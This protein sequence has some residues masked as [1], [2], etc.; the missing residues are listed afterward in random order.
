MENPLNVWLFSTGK[1]VTDSTKQTITHFMFN[2]GK[3]DI[4]SDHETFQE[5]Y[6]KYI[7]FKNCIVEKKTD[8]FKFFVDFDILSEEII[9]LD[10]YVCTIQTTLS[11]LY[12][13]DSLVCIVTGADKNKEVTKNGTM[14]LKQGF[15]LHWPDII[16][17]KETAKCIRKNLVIN[18]TNIFG[19]ND[20]HF[21]SWEK[22]IDK[23]VYENNGLR[24]VGSDKCTISDGIKHYE[25][26]IYILKE[27][28]IETKKDESLF[29]FYN[30][31]TFHLVKDTS[32]RSDAKKI[33]ETHGFLEY[34]E[35]E[36]TIETSSG[37]LVTLSRTS[38]EYK[39]IEKFFKL[40]ATGYRAEDIRA[41]SQ[42]K[43]KFMYLINSKSKYCQNKQD[44]HANNHIYFKLSPSGLCQKCM[45]ENE[46]IHGPCR[47]FQSTCVPITTSLESV[48][49][50]KKP[51]SKEVKKPQDFSLPGL[52]EK[53]ENNIT[54]K[55][56]FMGPGKKK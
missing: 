36:E 13:K 16:V 24:L 50:W 17:D 23:C 15:H 28:Y 30:T 43:D 54:S 52:L 56:N 51:K 11:N 6:S 31:D 40:H 55:D 19:K 34:V 45:S 7:K 22:I 48:L 8:F 27:V 47:E 32:I 39:A 38:V 10:E 4:S 46:G 9:N 20:K 41:I 3:L 49:N 1:M 33:T 18:L 53:L 14:Y 44:F 21:D 5:M 2:G 37:N 42:V 12:K 35:T 25:E 29:N 26:R